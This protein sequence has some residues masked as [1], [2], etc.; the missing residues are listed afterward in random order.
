MATLPTSDRVSFLFF[1]YVCLILCVFFLGNCESTDKTKEKK[2]TLPPVALNLPPS[3]NFMNTNKILKYS[4]GSF[5]VYGLRR[6]L[7]ENLSKVVEVSA[8]II[9]IENGCKN[10]PKG[11]SCPKPRL[12]VADDP[13]TNP[14]E[15]ERVMLVSDYEKIVLPKKSSILPKKAYKFS[16]QFV[17][18]SFEGFAATN[19]LVASTDPKLKMVPTTIIR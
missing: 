4:D 18:Q 2:P 7:N 13:N 6:N 19:G 10:P 15:I 16:G 17:Q 3:P 1:P 11:K 12:L 14:I 8:Y 5:S 9:E